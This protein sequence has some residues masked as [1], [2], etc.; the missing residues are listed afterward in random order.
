MA[1]I[2]SKAD[3]T[4]GTNLKLHIA[5]K[6]ASDLV[7]VDN[8]DGTGTITSTAEIADFASSSELTG[9]VN[10]GIVVGDILT[11]SHTGN[12][13]NEGLQVTVTDVT[14]NVITYDDIDTLTDESNGTD[15]NI[16]ATS[17]TYQFLEAGGLSFIDGVAGVVLASEMV[18]LWDATDLDIYDPAFTSIEPRAKSMAS[19]NGWEPHDVDT[20]KA[21]RD[22]ALEIRATSGTGA[23]KVYAC[24]RSGA[25]NA[26]TDQFTLWPSTDAWD[27]APTLATTTGYINELVLIYDAAGSDN[28]F[29]NGGITWITRCAEEG[30]TIIMEEF[31]LD[32]AEITPVSAANAIDPKLTV[33]DGVVSAGGDYANILYYSNDDGTDTITYS[34]DVNSVAYDFTGYVDGDLKTNEK[35]HAKINYLWR[36][37]T[38]INSDAGS[39]TTTEELRGDKQWPM[40]VFVGD[41]FTVQSYLV[42][43]N[44]GQRNNLTVVDS[45]GNLRSW[46]IIYTLVINADPAAY[47][48]ELSLIHADTFGTSAAVYLQ[49]ETPTDQK[50]ILIE[51]DGQQSIVIAYSTYAVDGHTPGDPIDLI[52]TWNRP[53]FIEPGNLSFTVSGD[54]SVSIVPKADPSYIA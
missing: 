45:T 54:T 9:I 41:G 25:L 27:T 42:D 29:S 33:A 31:E 28:R 23:N 38:N 50:D 12:V 37:P 40:T 53:G 43:Y 39:G 30:K 6:G 18:D 26:P 35:V 15:V 4:L 44:A 8:G 52:L 34:G 47:T 3:L 17:K 49:D 7:I 21:L 24:L 11:L 2:T 1:K 22:I 51:S 48:G 14:T 46:P 20:L 10:R 36:Q 16:V 19:I 13:L 5:D 32:Y